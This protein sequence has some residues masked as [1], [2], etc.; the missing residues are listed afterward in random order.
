LVYRAGAPAVSSNEDLTR[1][2]GKVDFSIKIAEVNYFDES[3][4]QVALALDEIA[5]E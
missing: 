4:E 2:A 1:E 3:A 5:K